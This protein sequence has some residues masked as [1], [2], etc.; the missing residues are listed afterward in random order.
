MPKRWRP[1]PT[2]APKARNEL[3]LQE[4]IAKD[5]ADKA[6]KNSGNAQALERYEAGLEDAGPLTVKDPLKERKKAE[7]KAKKE[8]K[9]LKKK[10]KKDKK[11]EKKDKKK[12]KEKKK[13][14]SSDSDSSDSS[15]DDSGDAA[16]KKQK[17]E[18]KAKSSKQGWKISDF[19]KNG[20][21]DD[22][23]DKPL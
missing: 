5:K 8:E 11:K 16:K 23:D 17:F 10:E 1:P 4:Y 6:A 2:Q 13:K 18:D 12:K 22:P 19:L 20:D 21:A 3:T 7:K 15:S 9:K 14:D